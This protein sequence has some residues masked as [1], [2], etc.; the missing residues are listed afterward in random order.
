MKALFIDHY[1]SFS[2]NVIDLLERVGGIEIVH[3]YFDKLDSVNIEAFDLLILSP[4]P[5]H[6]QDASD[7]LA[8]V[9]EYFDQ[10]PILGICLGHQIIAS[11]V[12][13]KISRVKSPHHGS[14]KEVFF[15]PDSELF[16]G[17]TIP[18]NVATYNSLSVKKEDW[19]NSEVTVIAWSKEGDVE[20]I[21]RNI[22]GKP[23]FAGIQFHP[24]SFL[25]EQ[26][27]QIM[28]NFILRLK[29]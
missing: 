20:A 2:F 18:L 4:G 16:K 10:K 29:H 26:S 3:C 1:D 27:V 11:Y 8:V 7:S 6:P 19:K 9:E 23:Y 24:E 13:E 15:D 14:V 28:K 12:G 22:S 25:S 5:N 21:E 17:I